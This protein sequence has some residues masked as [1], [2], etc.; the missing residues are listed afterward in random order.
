MNE[1]LKMVSVGLVGFLYMIVGIYLLYPITNGDEF[2]DL[3]QILA[4][5]WTFVTVMLVLVF[6]S[7]TGKEQKDR[8]DFDQ[9]ITVNTKIKSEGHSPEEFKHLMPTIGG[10]CKSTETTG[11]NNEVRN[12]SDFALI[13]AKKAI[14]LAKIK[15]NEAIELAKIEAN[16]TVELAK[17]EANRTV[18]PIKTVPYSAEMR[19]KIKNFAIRLSENPEEAQMIEAHLAQLE[20]SELISLIAYKKGNKEDIKKLISPK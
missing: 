10:E 5:L 18:E 4:I 15:A 17:V 11:F 16:R 3:Q 8:F 7:F 2:T 14:E 13:G 6:L 19:S 20:L 1:K 9:T 12:D